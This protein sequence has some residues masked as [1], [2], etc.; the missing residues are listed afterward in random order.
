[1]R[2]QLCEEFFRNEEYK[3]KLLFMILPYMPFNFIT[4]PDFI[5]YNHLH[6]HN[7]S[8]RICKAFGAL[9]IAYTIKSNEEH[10]KAKKDFE[11]FIFDDC[12]L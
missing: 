4:R 3:G 8:R 10:Q 7:I 6:A 11:L 12:I 5:A 1:M 2:G 9:S